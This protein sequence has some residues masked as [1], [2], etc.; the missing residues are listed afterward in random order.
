[1]RMK[2]RTGGLLRLWAVA[3]C[4]SLAACTGSLIPFAKEDTRLFNLSPKTT[5]S[6]NIPAVGW[7]LTVDTPVAQAALNTTRIALQRQ[8]LTLEY[9]SYA[10]WTDTAPVMVQTLLVESF[11]NSGKIVSVGRQSASLRADYNL[12]TELREFQA[13]YDGGNIP[14]VHVRLIAKLIKMPERTII[15]ASSFEAKEVASGADLIAVID[16]F[17]EALGKTLKRLVEWVLVTPG[18]TSQRP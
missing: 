14:T 4:L 7:Q 2:A 8:P 9:Y 15:A 5:F 6:P 17:D 11:A 16:A 3:A 10:N 18:H 13:E 12:L 1:M